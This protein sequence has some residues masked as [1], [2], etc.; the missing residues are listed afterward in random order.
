MVYLSM[1]FVCHVD[2]GLLCVQ[3]VEYSWYLGRFIK[4]WLDKRALAR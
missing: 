4:V 1:Y 3:M 2:G